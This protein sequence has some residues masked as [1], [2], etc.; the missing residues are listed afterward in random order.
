M[1]LPKSRLPARHPRYTYLT[2]DLITG[3]LLEDIPLGQ[4]RFNR[5]LNDA[6]MLTG[7][8][9]YTARTAALL[10]PATT[11]ARTVLY[12]LRDNQAVWGGI[13]WT[14]R[15]DHANRIVSLGC[16]DWWSYPEHRYITADADFTNTD[17]NDIIRS[18]I[19]TMATTPVGGDLSLQLSSGTSGRALDRTYYGF[20]YLSVAEAVRQLAEDEGGPDFRA[21][22][23][24]TLETGITRQLLIGTPH[25]G[26]SAAETGLVLDYGAQGAALR[27]LV[28]T[29]DGSTTETRHYALGPGTEDAKLIGV[30]TR[31][32][33]TTD[34][35][36]PLLEGTTSYS[37]DTLDSDE[38][39][40]AKAR[41]DLTS[42]AGVRTLPTG[43]TR[44]LEVGTIEPGD[45]VR[46]EVT[47]DW[48]NADPSRDT[49]RGIWTQ[50]TRVTSFTVDVPDDGGTETV[51]PTFGDLVVISRQIQPTTGPTTTAL[52]L[53]APSAD[54]GDYGAGD[55]G[56][57]IYGD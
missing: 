37:D 33:L 5:G 52:T 29:E 18:L 49:L 14:R 50:T 20:N 57:G 56:S 4:V 1:T 30:A 32:D 39:I 48:Y 54:P 3:T 22:T 10:R 9:A 34:Y 13:I 43:T 45:E 42:R 40:A 19:T 17:Q 47:A 25:L 2:A 55:Y 15:V 12:A 44:V 7:A 31:S 8:F 6:G 51:T 41:A 35:G 21:D 11:P 27:D 26:R 53:G 28:E 24:G 36:W 16:A 38:A 46:L 23:V